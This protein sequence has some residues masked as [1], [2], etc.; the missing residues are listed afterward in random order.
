MVW[1]CTSSVLVRRRVVRRAAR[2]ETRPAMAGVCVQSSRVRCSAGGV[3]LLA[4]GVG[5]LHH[6]VGSVLGR[7]L[8]RGA[9][10]G[11][12]PLRQVLVGGG[13]TVRRCPPCAPRPGRAC[14]PGGRRQRRGCGP[15]SSLKVVVLIVFYFFLP[16]ASRGLTSR[17][18]AETVERSTP[19]NWARGRVRQPEPQVDESDGGPSAKMSRCLRLAPAARL[20]APL[21]I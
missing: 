13:G 3:P 20:R 14:V 15:C 12:G 19:S 9:D 7:F 10:L 2:S 18:A 1:A 5:V 6:A 16:E 8:R 4:L 17:I 11:R 21:R